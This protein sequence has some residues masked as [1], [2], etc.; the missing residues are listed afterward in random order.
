M[1]Q[2]FESKAPI[3]VPEINP[4]LRC[5]PQPSI[6]RPN[7][8]STISTG[9]LPNPCSSGI[10]TKK[11]AT[12]ISDSTDLFDSAISGGVGNNLDTIVKP[13]YLFYLVSYNVRTLNQ[14]EMQS[15]QARTPETFKTCDVSNRRTRNSM[16]VITLRSSDKISHLTLR[17]SGGPV[18]NAGRQTGVRIALSIRFLD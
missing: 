1:D 9:D 4:L 15:A 18:F 17:M 13:N 2:T 5:G 7:A 16:L 8:S 14:I 12:K 11:D 6:A 3:G 10:R